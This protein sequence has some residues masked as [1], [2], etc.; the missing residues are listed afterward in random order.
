MFYKFLTRHYVAI[1]CCILIFAFVTR[2]YRVSEPKGYIFDEVYHAL[3]AKLIRRNDPRAYEWWHQAIEP[4]TAIDWL[5]PPLAK[6]TQALSM[7]IFGENSFGWRFSSVVFGVFVILATAILADQLFHNKVLSLLAGLLA[8]LD[9]LLLVQSRIA[10][11]DIHVT[12]FILLTCI[13]YVKFRQ[14]LDDQKNQRLAQ[15]YLL[16]TGLSAGLAMGSKWSGIFILGV[17]WFFEIARVVA[18]GAVKKLSFSWM[19]T[20]R[21][22]IFLLMTPGI[23]YLLSYTH[24][25][26]QGK[27]LICEGDHPIQ[28]QCYCEQDSSWWVDAL[29]TA[30]PSNAA[31]WEKLEARGGCKR[32]ISHFSELHHQIWWYQTNLTATHPFQSRPLQWFLDLRPVW[33]Y[34]SY[35]D[36]TI[37]NIYTQGNPFL[38]WFGD[39]AV[40]VTMGWLIMGDAAVEKKKS[41]LEVKMTLFKNF[42]TQ[43]LPQLR[44]QKMSER[45]QN[46]WPL[47]FVLIA[48]LAVWVLWEFSPRIMFF[49]HY[50]PAVPFLC[51][52]L[53]YWLM[54]LVE[55]KNVN[56]Q[57]LALAALAII[58]LTFLV[59]YPNWTG[60]PVPKWV[61]ENIYF[62]LPS[63]R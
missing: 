57:Y 58:F 53:A 10:M 56:G 17:V 51:I 52:L 8:S 34:V 36:N 22:F 9:G 5:H 13:L 41:G 1:L 59:F 6:Y 35:T 37:A 25:F 30:F 21:T 7:D 45:E 44:K 4:N 16:L 33:F 3:T 55:R 18:T 2:I 14:L 29:K 62:L 61:A 60:I 19:A 46:F 48:Y 28:G 23:V 38:F 31:G 54:K 50:T 27:S 39:I 11:N 49:Y 63:W 24:M 20:L 47:L 40:I 26:L 15:F 12:F 32:L 42:F 43:H